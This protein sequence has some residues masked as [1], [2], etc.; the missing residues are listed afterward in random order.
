[1]CNLRLSVSLGNLSPSPMAG[2]WEVEIQ[3]HS[4]CFNQVST[5]NGLI[6]NWRSWGPPTGPTER[7]Q[8]GLTTPTHWNVARGGSAAKWKSAGD[9]NQWEGAVVL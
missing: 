5:L 4:I 3:V 9:A 7:T 6:V 2:C 1:M 8:P